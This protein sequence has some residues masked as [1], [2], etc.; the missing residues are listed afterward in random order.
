MIGDEEWETTWETHLLKTTLFQ[1]ARYLF[2]MRF[3]LLKTAPL[4]FTFATFLNRTM[5]VR[6][7]FDNELRQR[8]YYAGSFKTIEVISRF[9]MRCLEVVPCKNLWALMLY[10]CSEMRRNFEYQ[11]TSVTCVVATTDQLPLFLGARQEGG[12]KSDW[13][14]LLRHMETP[15]LNSP[16]TDFMHFPFKYSYLSY[17]SNKLIFTRSITF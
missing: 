4:L 2:Y 8:G 6:R 12:P 1:V 9:T 17:M 14:P 11:K 7:L 5:L 15:E 16:R 13:V 10:A 3:K